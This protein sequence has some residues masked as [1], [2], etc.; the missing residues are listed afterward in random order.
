MNFIILLNFKDD[1]ASL[2]QTISL[3][4]YLSFSKLSNVAS[5]DELICSDQSLS[6]DKDNLVI[7]AL[8]LMR[9]KTKLNNYFK[10]YLVKNVPVQAGLGGGSG[11]AATAMHAFNVLSGYPGNMKNVLYFINSYNIT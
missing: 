6:V 4:D 7:K 3:S 11:N 10:I 5:S 8:N 1:L 2:F 9:E